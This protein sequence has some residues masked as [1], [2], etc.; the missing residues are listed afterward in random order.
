MCRN[1]DCKSNFLRSN[2]RRLHAVEERHGPSFTVLLRDASIDGSIAL[3]LGKP[4]R[5]VAPAVAVKQV[6]RKSSRTR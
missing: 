5:I 6:E 3:A 1:D 4:A 2:G